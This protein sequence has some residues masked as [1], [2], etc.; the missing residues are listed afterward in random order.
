MIQMKGFS[1]WRRGLSDFDNEVVY[2][3]GLI[4]QVPDVLSKLYFP[5]HTE[6]CKPID[7]EISTIGSSPVALEQQLK[8]KVMLGTF[9]M[10]LFFVYEGD[11]G[12]LRR[13]NHWHIDY[14]KL[15]YHIVSEEACLWWLTTTSYQDTMTLQECM[16]P[17]SR[18]TIDS[19]VLLMIALLLVTA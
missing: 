2:R 12:L 5:S 3:P 8:E 11:D 7:D 10:D 9:C 13:Q 6:I 18:S 17:Y 19:R 15:S 14:K 16:P 4:H 1:R